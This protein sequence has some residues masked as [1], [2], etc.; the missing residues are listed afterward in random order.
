MIGT[1]IAGLTAARLLDRTHEVTLYE[2]DTTGRRAHEHDSRRRPARR[3]LGRHRLHRPQRPQLPPVHEAAGGARGGGPGRGDGDVDRLRRR[4]LRVRQHPPRAVRAALQPAAA[5]VLAP[6]PRPAS[7]QPRGPAARRQAGRPDGRRVPAR[8]GLFDAGFASARS[9][10][11]SRRS[12]RPTRRRSGS[13]RSASSPSSSRTT[14]SCS[15]PAG[16]GGGRSR[17]ARATTSSACSSASRAAF[18]S[19]SP[20]RAVERLGRRRPG[21]R[22]RGRGRD[23]RPGGDRDPLRSGAGDA[24]RA[25]RRRARGP[26]RDA[27]PAPTR[28]CCTPTPR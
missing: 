11:R 4:P 23:L 14:A 10:P 25:D 21:R 22:R 18:E 26:G 8:R 15:S 3:A 17:A 16:R 24:R 2:A 5:A 20:V 19:A 27:L 12:G 9:C 13:S 1:G 7:L 28:R 6:D